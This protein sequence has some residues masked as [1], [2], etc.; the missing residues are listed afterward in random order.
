MNSL[1]EL[2]VITN[3]PEFKDLREELT[4]WTTRS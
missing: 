1:N 4:L 3:L 2:T